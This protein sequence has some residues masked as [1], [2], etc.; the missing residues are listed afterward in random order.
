RS[1]DSFYICEHFDIMDMLNRKTVPKLIL[2]IKNEEVEL[3]TRGYKYESVFCI[4]NKG[5]VSANQIQV[6]LKVNSPFKIS[7]YGIDGNG[8]K[9]MKTTPTKTNFTKYYG[10]SE[11]VIHPETYHEVDKISLNEIGNGLPIDDLIIEYEIIAEGM[12]LEKG[13]ITR[14]KEELLKIIKQ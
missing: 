6:F 2:E 13:S 5:K 3:G 4:V 8:F 11:L 1:G 14:K 10:G 12:K 7:N 9:G